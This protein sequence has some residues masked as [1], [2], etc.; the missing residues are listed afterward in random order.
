MFYRF[1]FMYPWR[2]LQ[3]LLRITIA[4][5][6]SSENYTEG[7]KS[8][9]GNG[10]LVETFLSYIIWKCSWFSRQLIHEADVTHGSAGLDGRK[11]VQL[12]QLSA[13]PQKHEHVQN[14]SNFPHMYID[15]L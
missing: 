15:M 4:M 5:K 7:L 11:S 10:N 12:F 2:I 8:T 13:Q 9:H 14:C 3:W 1:G 6:K